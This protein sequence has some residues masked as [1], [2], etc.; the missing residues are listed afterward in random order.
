MPRNFRNSAMGQA[1]QKGSLIQ[2]CDKGILDNKV[3]G[4]ANYNDVTSLSSVG[5]Y[6]V[7][8]HRGGTG[9]K[10]A[11]DHR[12]AEFERVAKINNEKPGPGRYRSPSEFGQYDGNDI[13]NTYNTISVTRM[14]HRR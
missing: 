9:G 4:P 6:I 1:D 11:K 13:Y 3:P 10:F 14:N 5:K 2:V 8:S 12:V 7:S